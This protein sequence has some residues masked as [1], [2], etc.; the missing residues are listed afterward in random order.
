[1]NVELGESLYF[2]SKCFSILPLL[3]H[4]I[5]SLPLGSCSFIV[6]LYI[7]DAYFLLILKKFWSLSRYC[8]SSFF[9]E[10]I[11][12][13]II[14][15]SFFFMTFNVYFMC[16]RKKIK[17]QKKK[18]SFLYRILYSFLSCVLQF[19]FIFSHA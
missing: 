8:L 6:P 1:M 15:P 13:G 17:G 12:L 18:K 10:L 14:R 3:F 2:G 4:R 16:K 9:L 7:K 11:L 5:I 19:T